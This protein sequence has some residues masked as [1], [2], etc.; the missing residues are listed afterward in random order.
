MYNPYI[1]FC[2]I[3]YYFSLLTFLR[4]IKL[5]SNMGTACCSAW[6]KYFFW[7]PSGT[8]N[9]VWSG[10]SLLLYQ[11]QGIYLKVAVCIFKGDRC[12][13]EIVFNSPG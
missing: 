3:K 12:A 11:S 6:E 13:K 1:T 10:K 9:L 7:S 5:E 4:V 8:N 2:I